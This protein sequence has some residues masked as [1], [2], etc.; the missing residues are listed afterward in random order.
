[1]QQSEARLGRNR[2][3]CHSP[4]LPATTTTLTAEPESR[5]GPLA[6]VHV[7]AYGAIALPSATRLD[8]EAVS[9]SLAGNRNI[10]NA[11]TGWAQRPRVGASPV[12]R[13]RSGSPD[14]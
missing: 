1:M 4:V 11:F 8:R 9:G 14:A 3:L 10:V 7:S 5:P 6:L 2:R 12:T 13:T